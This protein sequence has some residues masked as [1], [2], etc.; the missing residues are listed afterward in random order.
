M[1]ILAAFVVPHPPIILSEIGHGEEKKIQKTIDAY[2]EVM[3]QA[4]A[5]KP[6]TIVLTSPHS[7]MYADYFQISPGEKAAGDFG[8]FRAPEV[9]IEADYDEDF[10]RMLV[11]VCAGQK[12]PAGT[13]GARSAALDHGTMIPLRF[14]EEQ[15][16]AGSCKLVRIGL[17]GLPA[18]VHYHLGQCIAQVAEKLQRRVVFIASGDL[19]H[20][21]TEEGPYGFAAEGPQFDERCTAALGK[22]DFLSLLQMDEVFC[23]AAAECGLHSFWIMA[24]ALDRKAVESRLLSYEGPFGVGYGVASFLVTGVD[25]SRNIGEQLTACEQADLRDRKAAE[26]AYVKLARLSIETFVRTRSY[27]ALP[28]D[29]PAQL[30]QERAGAF[31]S[32]KEHGHLR[33]CIGTIGPTQDSLADEILYNAVSAAANDPRF[34]PIQPDEL[35]QLVYSV[36]VLGAPEPVESSQELNAAEYGVIVETKDGRRGLLLPDLAGVTTPQKQMDIARQKAN[37]APHEPV[38]LW[39][40]KVVRHK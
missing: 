37:I 35:P 23:E 32:I 39:R 19:S 4:A 5:L 2:R 1:A 14:W 17:S 31:V 22:G 20:K 10:V 15:P 33:G 12:I 16:D 11:D 34:D 25:E 8:Q 29:L 38:K 30:T 26:D 40:F 13:I 9:K 18:L 21:L 6:D 36:D 24:G 27:A 3:R 28:A 7:V